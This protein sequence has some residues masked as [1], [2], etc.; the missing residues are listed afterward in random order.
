MEKV[1]PV[2][3]MF[4]K[5]IIKRAIKR[6]AGWSAVLTQMFASPSSSP[7]ACI[8]IYHRVADLGFVDPQVDDWNARSAPGRYCRRCAKSVESSEKL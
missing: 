5:I 7:R 6:T 8:L 1:E 2:H 4:G 3:A